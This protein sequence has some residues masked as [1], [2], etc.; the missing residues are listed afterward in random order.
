MSRRKVVEG[1]QVRRILVYGN[2]KTD[3]DQYW[4]ASTEELEAGAF[5][6]LFKLLDESWKVYSSLKDDPYLPEFPKEH[7]EGCMC[8]PCKTARKYR[9]EAPKEKANNLR[10]LELYKRAKKGEAIAAKALLTAR[11]DDEYEEFRFAFVESATA[12]YPKREW[13]VTKPCGTAYV[14][15]SGLTLWGNHNRMTYSFSNGLKKAIERLTGKQGVLHYDLATKEEV[16]I[17]KLWDLS[18]R[19]KKPEETDEDYV[20]WVMG[21]EPEDAK[22]ALELFKKGNFVP[23]KVLKFHKQVCPSCKREMERFDP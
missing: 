14:H 6:E 7:P 4:D 11:K 9:E 12:T 2:R 22:A 8:E 20:Q 21:C 5:L 13:G 10:M 17:D 1:A 19:P 3:G 15:E 18:F 23:G 16:T